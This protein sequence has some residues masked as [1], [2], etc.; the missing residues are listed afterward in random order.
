MALIS[1]GSDT[2]DPTPGTA[3]A[4]SHGLGVSPDFVNLTAKA[5]GTLYMTA[6]GSVTF[7]VASSVANLPF[8]WRAVV[9]HSIIK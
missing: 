7:A 5:N 8:D 3:K 1:S 2:C 6:K 9:D 4:I